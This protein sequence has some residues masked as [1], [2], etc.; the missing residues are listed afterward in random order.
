MLYFIIFVAFKMICAGS[1]LKPCLLV[2]FFSA[3][4]LLACAEKCCELWAW[5][6]DPGHQQPVLTGEASLW[7]FAAGGLARLAAGT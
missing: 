2:A 3:D 4:A 1:I 5:R 7:T 6:T